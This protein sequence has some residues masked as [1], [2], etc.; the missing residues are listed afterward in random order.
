MNKNNT[1]F[2]IIKISFCII[3]LLLSGFAFYALAVQTDVTENII[4]LFNTSFVIEPVILVLIGM[5]LFMLL[6]GLTYIFTPNKN[7]NSMFYWILLLFSFITLPDIIQTVQLV[8]SF[9]TNEA[10]SFFTIH[11]D[12][13][14]SLSILSEFPNDILL[15]IIMLFCFVRNEKF[16][17]KK[18]EIVLLALSLLL[19][20]AMLFL[21][22]IY[23]LILFAAVY[24][25]IILTHSLFTEF[26]SQI[27]K[28]YE[29]VISL[30][31]LT[32]LV[33]KCIYRA[34]LIINSYLL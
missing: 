28:R 1:V 31:I 29:K 6:L 24:C 16:Y 12:L 5:F 20:I 23:H 7:V 17:I 21:P 19:C 2:N 4:M 22:A 14:N 26:M 10:G 3:I 9:Q 32:L 34:L 18:K 15:L 30:C 33:C 13:L 11:F 27:D 8:H 25:L